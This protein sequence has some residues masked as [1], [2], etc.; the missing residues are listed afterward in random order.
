MMVRAWRCC[1]I[2]VGQGDSLERSSVSRAWK[3]GRAQISGER[4]NSSWW[5]DQQEGQVTK[6]SEGSGERAGDERR[7]LVG[8]LKASKDFGFSL[9]E[10]QFVHL[11]FFSP[12]VLS[13]SINSH[14]LSFSLSIVFFT[15][16]QCKTN[17]GVVMNLRIS[18][19]GLY[20]LIWRL[21]PLFTFDFHSKILE[22]VWSC[23][24]R[25]PRGSAET[26]LVKVAIRHFQTFIFLGLSAAFETV[27][28]PSPQF[29]GHSSF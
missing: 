24:S 25:L 9:E 16:P 15:F 28:S 8:A 2:S 12:W 17:L 4:A 27:N 22:K 5:E 26:A 14:I 11:W 23:A 1:F 10:K 18:S 19:S 13:L 20:P 29:L 21:R 6:S 7:A 3:E